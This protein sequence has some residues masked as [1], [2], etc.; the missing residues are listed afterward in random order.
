ME[1]P[2][3]FA[4]NILR[5]L[6]ERVANASPAL[7]TERGDLF[8]WFGMP[9]G[10]IKLK[11]PVSEYFEFTNSLA[12]EVRPRPINLVPVEG[13]SFEVVVYSGISP[14]TVKEGLAFIGEKKLVLL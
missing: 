1:K 13:K 7:S 14:L 10:A 2:L 6:E 5:E 3:R 8:L 12:E 4:E 9:F 11:I